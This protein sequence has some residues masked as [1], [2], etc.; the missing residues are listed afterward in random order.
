MKEAQMKLMSRYI[1]SLGATAFAVIGLLLN[2]SCAI[3]A[4]Q[5]KVLDASRSTATKEAD[6][7]ERN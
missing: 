2:A 6:F 1:F 7:R 4:T 5:T 3:A